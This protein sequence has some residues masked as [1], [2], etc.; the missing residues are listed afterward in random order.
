[1]FSCPDCGRTFNTANSLSC[2]RYRESQ[3]KLEHRCD[4][5]KE[6]K[7]K[8]QNL[9]DKIL[10]GGA[11]SVLETINATSKTNE[12]LHKLTTQMDDIKQQ[13]TDI[14][15]QNTNMAAEVKDLKFQ[16]QEMKEMVGEFV[17]NPSLLILVDKLCPIQDLRKIDL[18]APIFKPVKQI[19]DCEIREYANMM[20][21]ETGVVHRKAVKKLIEIQPTVAKDGEK[22]FCNND[23]TLL[24]CGE[25]EVSRAFINVFANSGYK[26][27][28]KALQD[29]SDADYKG[30]VMK[31]AGC[32]EVVPVID[33]FG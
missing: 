4:S 25:S 19:L 9:N 22:L 21:H 23:G 11:N 27:A 1:M 10:T 24:K 6:R 26:Y 29:L 33:M 14:K 20:N 13:N 3:K 2:H 15:Q 31:N 30:D 7:R 16:N 8:I 17:R 32:A 28:E 18:Q 12:I 5:K